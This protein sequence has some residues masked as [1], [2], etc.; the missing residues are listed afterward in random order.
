M[1]LK[2]S[3]SNKIELDFSDSEKPVKQQ[4]RACRCSKGFRSV[5]GHGH[6]HCRHCNEPFRYRTLMLS[7]EERV[8]GKTKSGHVD[9]VLQ[10]KTSSDSVTKECRLSSS[11]ESKNCDKSSSTRQNTDKCH[12]NNQA[13]DGKPP[14]TETSQDSCVSKKK[15]KMKQSDSSGVKSVSLKYAT[16][17]TIW[18]DGR[19]VTSQVPSYSGNIVFP[20]VDRRNRKA[21][22]PICDKLFVRKD[23]LRN[24]MICV[25]NIISS[26]ETLYSCIPCKFETSHSYLFNG[27]RDSQMHR[28]NVELYRGRFYSSTA[29]HQ[30]QS[31]WPSDGYFMNK[32]PKVV[33]HGQKHHL[34]SS[35]CLIGLNTLPATAD[36]AT[37]RKLRSRKSLDAPAIKVPTT[38]ASV[39]SSKASRKLRSSES[40]KKFTARKSTTQPLMVAFDFMDKKKEVSVTQK[41][42]KTAKTS[43]SGSVDHK[44]SSPEKAVTIINLDS[45]CEEI[46]AVESSPIT[47]PSNSDQK[48]ISSR[49]RK[50]RSVLLINK[51]KESLSTKSVSTGGSSKVQNPKSTCATGSDRSEALSVTCSSSSSSPIVV[52]VSQ[53]NS[54]KPTTSTAVKM[55]VTTAQPT[56]VSYSSSLSVNSPVS[57]DDT[58]S[59]VTWSAA[60][61]SVPV[62][63]VAKALPAMTTVTPTTPT[64]SSRSL[65]SLH[66]F[67]AE[68]LWSE[69]CRRGGMRT[70]DCGVSF[71]DSTLYLLHRSCHSDLA[72]LKCAFCDYKADTSYDFHAHLLDH[73]K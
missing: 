69:L 35:Q 62:I 26:G 39:D 36:D 19:E 51:Q 46:A 4:L 54:S 49:I 22:C 7:H 11:T 56:R 59:A 32:T 10:D 23:T 52:S 47:Q 72:P 41:V 53:Q 43:V 28:S 24:H 68:T 2:V 61:R 12:Q 33:W 64:V 8:H 14:A 50:L 55:P 5:T 20:T 18:A 57:A 60:L 25:H 38:P 9:K 3:G 73:K 48:R 17:V 63:G 65:Y 1:I 31:F 45:D 67:S 16:R 6:F 40:Q 66:R 42:S 70:C 13:C 15:K 30:S 27:H 44:A 34:C 71:M 58:V 37:N 21:R 29:Q